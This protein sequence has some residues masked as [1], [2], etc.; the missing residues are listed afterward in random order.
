MILVNPLKFFKKIKHNI[1][2][3]YRFER[4]VDYLNRKY[5]GKDYKSFQFKA[6]PSDEFVYTKNLGM[7]INLLNDKKVKSII[8]KAFELDELIKS[9]DDT[10]LD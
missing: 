2:L 10:W 9:K 4:Y 6:Y 7:K 3:R 8:K 5:Y 1:I